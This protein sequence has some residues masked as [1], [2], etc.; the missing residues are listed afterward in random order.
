MQAARPNPPNWGQL[1]ETAVGQ[2]GYVTTQQ[3]QEA[4]YS[5]PLL[6]HHVKQGRLLR[7][8][9]GIYR[10]MHYPAGEQEDLIVLWLWTEQQGVFSH[11]T[12]LVL[13]DLSDALPAVYH[14][15]LPAAWSR[16]RL[17][18]P[19][20]VRLYYADVS[21]TDRRWVGNVPVTSPLRTLVD[22]VAAHVSPEFV[23]DARKQ[24]LQRGL[25]S[26]TELQDRMRQL[27]GHYF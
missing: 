9:R 4:G 13:Q 27:P 18:V 25:A 8:R 23:R 24:I 5:L 1:Y 7:A 14:L 15:T 11:E 26:A 6:T 2:G 16:R 21:D 22:C 10:L 12:A 20:G 3:A 19:E 17:R